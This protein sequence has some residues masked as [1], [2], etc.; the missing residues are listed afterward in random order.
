MKTI[1][2]VDIKESQA[3]TVEDRQDFHGTGPRAIGIVCTVS[4]GNVFSP[5]MSLVMAACVV[6]VWPRWHSCLYRV[7]WCV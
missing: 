1:P 4:E 5:G 7:K 2:V 3:G 6:T